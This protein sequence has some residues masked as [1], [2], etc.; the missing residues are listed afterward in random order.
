[1][2]HQ[3]KKIKLFFFFLKNDWGLR[4]RTVKPCMQF[5]LAPPGVTPEWSQDLCEGLSTAECDPKTEKANKYKV[6]NL[7]K[8]SIITTD[9]KQH[10]PGS[11]EEYMYK[12]W[13]I[14]TWKISL[15]KDCYIIVKCHRTE[16]DDFT[17]KMQ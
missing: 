16:M 17:D 9:F 13:Q 5:T 15:I 14:N 12:L 8:N 2:V 1:M 10:T 11:N 4:G 6:R 3:F 7:K